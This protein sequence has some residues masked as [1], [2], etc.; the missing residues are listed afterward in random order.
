MLLEIKKVS[1]LEPI[2]VQ[3]L[4]SNKEIKDKFLKLKFSPG[5]KVT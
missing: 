3:K 1:F 5:S 4:I 2:W